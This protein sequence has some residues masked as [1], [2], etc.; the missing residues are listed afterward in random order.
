M[1]K[2]IKATF[3]HIEPIAANM[4]EAD[5]TEV[6]LSAHLTP[7]QAILDGFSMSVKAWTIMDGDTPIGMFGVSSVSV[8]GTMGVPWLLG[9]DGMLKIKRKFIRES[10]QYL[11]ECHKL[12]PQLVNFVHAGNVQSLRWL[13]WMGF[14]FE[15]PMAAGPD[16][17]E[18][19]KFE[20]SCGV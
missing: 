5:V 10:M 14:D 17:A 6:W 8:L 13:T 15:G 3:E 12:Y 7:H 2:V 16:G 19:F 9:T 1:A 20:R 11:D 18:F 4:R